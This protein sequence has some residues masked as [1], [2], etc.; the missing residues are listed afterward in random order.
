MKGDPSVRRWVVLRVGP[1]GT[2]GEARPRR[3][4]GERRATWEPLVGPHYYWAQRWM[5]ERVS[6]AGGADKCHF[7]HLL[8]VAGPACPFPWRAWLAVGPAAG[9][10]VHPTIQRWVTTGV[11]PA[12]LHPAAAP[13]PPP[14]TR[15]TT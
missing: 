9:A 4:M 12:P 1:R 11:V 7:S 14:P 3:R 13:N 5:R 2:H 8:E 15:R 10:T 6:D